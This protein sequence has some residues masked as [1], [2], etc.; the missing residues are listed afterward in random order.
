MVLQPIQKPTWRTGVMKRIRAIPLKQR[1]DMIFVVVLLLGQ[2]SLMV[3]G[4]ISVS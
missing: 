3:F 1:H 4:V 2:V